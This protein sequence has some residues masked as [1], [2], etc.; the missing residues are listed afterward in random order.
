MKKAVALLLTWETTITEQVDTS[1]SEESEGEDEDSTTST[2]AMLEDRYANATVN[3]LDGLPA[4]STSGR[5]IL[6]AIVSRIARGEKKQWM[7]WTRQGILASEDDD[8]VVIL[9]TNPDLS[10][11]L[12]SRLEFWERV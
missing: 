10:G 5:Y 12:D 4:E 7:T 11:L 2:L 3:Q 9:N 1:D 6:K 8:T